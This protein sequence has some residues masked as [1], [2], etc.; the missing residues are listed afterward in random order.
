MFATLKRAVISGALFIGT[1]SFTA[2]VVA[3]PAFADQMLPDFAQRVSTI[4]E[5]KLKSCGLLFVD[6]RTPGLPFNTRWNARY[7]VVNRRGQAL[8]YYVQDYGNGASWTWM[9]PNGGY[10]HSIQFGNWGIKFTT[11]LAG[12]VASAS[13]YVTPMGAGYNMYCRAAGGMV[14]TWQVFENCVASQFVAVV[15]NQLCQYAN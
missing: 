1:A 12:N 13:R 4:I 2:G 8:A 6:P 3:T 15:S 10:R 5:G 14:P 9:N 7:A 11:P